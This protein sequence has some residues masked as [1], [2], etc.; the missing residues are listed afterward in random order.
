MHAFYEIVIFTAAMPDY[1]NWVLDSI[2]KN[3]FISFRLFRHHTISIE[4]GKTHI[5][6]LSRLGRNLDTLL[7]VDNL[8]ENF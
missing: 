8:A 6:D 4:G 2:D 1:A 5:K 3:N 7:I